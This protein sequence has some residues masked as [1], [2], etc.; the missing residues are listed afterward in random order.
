MWA[1]VNI[2]IQLH[3]YEPIWKVSVSSVNN[4]YFIFFLF[5]NL[6][7]IFLFS[8]SCFMFFYI[9]N[10]E[11]FTTCLILLF[12]ICFWN[13]GRFL[14]LYSHIL[15]LISPLWTLSSTISNKIIFL[16]SFL[17]SAFQFYIIIFCFSINDINCT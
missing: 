5:I 12:L 11:F 16:Y 13:V 10:N 8:F 14:F 2:K 4:P 7:Y 6:N 3:G 15:L 17:S 9:I 1:F